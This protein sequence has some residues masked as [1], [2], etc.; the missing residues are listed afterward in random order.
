MTVHLIKLSVGPDSLSDLADWQAR[1][2]KELKRARKTPELMHITRHMPK[3][4]TEVLDGGSIYWVI[5]GWLCARQKMLELRPITYNGAPHCGLIHDP[6]LIRIAPRKHRPFQGWRYFNPKD[7]P[8]D[9]VVNELD[10]TMPEEL[11]REL[12]VLGLL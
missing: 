4:A 5:N 9:L 11:R 3:R 2:L 10:P 12:S 1:R 6:E 8:R 7:A